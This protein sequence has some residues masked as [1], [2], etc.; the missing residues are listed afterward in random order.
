MPTLGDYLCQLTALLACE[1]GPCQAPCHR[2]LRK[3]R[4][5]AAGITLYLP[6]E[7]MGTELPGEYL[8]ERLLTQEHA[9]ISERCIP[10]WHAK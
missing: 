3:A 7:V 1:S 9:S 5:F 2:C 10:G 6:T 4:I 8:L